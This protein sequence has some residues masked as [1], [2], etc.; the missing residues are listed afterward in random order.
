MY[1]YLAYLRMSGGLKGAEGQPQAVGGEATAP[2]N[3]SEDWELMCESD[4]EAQAAAEQPISVDS[5]VDT[6]S[7]TSSLSA[8]ELPPFPLH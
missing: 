4:V 8:G 5:P 7:G 3:T 6:G 1:K 2:P